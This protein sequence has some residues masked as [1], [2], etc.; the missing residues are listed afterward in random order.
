[1]TPTSKT[2][3][4]TARRLTYR[5]Y[6]YAE[7]T[8]YAAVEYGS[9]GELSEVGT[10]LRSAWVVPGDGGLAF[11]AYWDYDADAWLSTEKWKDGKRRDHIVDGVYDPTGPDPD[12]AKVDRATA[13]KILETLGATVGLDDPAIGKRADMYL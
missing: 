6:D 7:Y 5:T 8:Y 3:T 2:K 13:L 11:G 4:G 12:I 10:L 9:L 1:M